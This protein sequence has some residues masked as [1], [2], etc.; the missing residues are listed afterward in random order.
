MSRTTLRK[1]RELGLSWPPGPVDPPANEDESFDLLSEATGCESL[2]HDFKGDS[3]Y[4]D[5][6]AEFEE[7]ASKLAKAI[8]GENVRDVPTIGP[9]MTRRKL[10][11]VGLRWPEPTP[12]DP[13]EPIDIHRYGEGLYW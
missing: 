9:P 3:R 12:T 4:L 8:K 11:S 10:E 6:K 7:L 13:D 5:Q 2:Y 1:L